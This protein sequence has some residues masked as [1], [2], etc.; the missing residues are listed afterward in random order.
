MFR[1][2]SFAILN[3]YFHLSLPINLF[4]RAVIGGDG[5][6][7]AAWIGRNGQS[8][9]FALS[10]AKRDGCSIELGVVVGNGIGESRNGG[11]VVNREIG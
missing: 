3:S 6:G 10:F 9:R 5:N 8:Y 4:F 1:I 2:S 11:V 7:R